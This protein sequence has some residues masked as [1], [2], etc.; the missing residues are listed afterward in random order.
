M[1][2][3]RATSGAVL[4]GGLVGTI[5]SYVV[6]YQSSIGFLW[7]STFVLGATVATAMAIVAANAVRGVGAPKA[8]QHLTWYAVMNESVGP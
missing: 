7:P 4:A 2:S 3:R 8:G 6:A 5:V 1:F